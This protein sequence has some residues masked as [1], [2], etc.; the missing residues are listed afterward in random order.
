MSHLKNTNPLLVIIIGL[1]ISLVSLW[2]LI[3]FFN[4]NIPIELFANTYWILAFIGAIA[5][6]WSARLW[7]YFGSS[8]GKS[9]SFFSLGL[10]LQVFG[11]LTYS[12]Y[13]YVLHAD[14]PYPSIGDLGFFGSV[15]L[16]IYG[17]WIIAD[18][19]GLRRAFRK[20][21]LMHKFQVILVPLVIA[22]LT[23]AFFLWGKHIALSSPLTS[24]L[25]FGY[26]IGQ[27]TYVTI[28]ILAYMLSKK[29]LGGAMKNSILITV[30]ALFVQYV[31]DAMF[32]YQNNN[33]TWVG[34]GF[35]DLLYLT[36]YFLLAYAFVTFSQVY[37]RVK[38]Q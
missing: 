37:D 3:H 5:G 24:F 16:Y 34:G 27:A 1:Y 31:A 36:A 2:I 23:L 25:D 11:Q 33:G 19:V 38:S 15:L 30:F 17:I 32:L 9:I 6:L 12:F 14:T 29:Y 7:G 35:N 4:I 13:I 26:P 28:A 21:D 20:M 8:I 10:L 22:I 18:T